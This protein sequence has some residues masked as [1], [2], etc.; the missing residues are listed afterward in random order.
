MDKLLIIILI[1]GIIYLIYLIYKNKD[2]IDKYVGKTKKKIE[3]FSSDDDVL[4]EHS[5]NN[6]KNSLVKT[7]N[8]SFIASDS[9]N[10]S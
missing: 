8:E 3:K 5:D 1:I 10:S 4:S 2:F 7:D 6:S 9:T